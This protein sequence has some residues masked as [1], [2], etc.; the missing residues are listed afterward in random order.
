MKEHTRY[1]ALL[2]KITNLNVGL[3]PLGFDVESMFPGLHLGLEVLLFPLLEL[4]A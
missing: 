3:Y 1:K 2:T 4:E